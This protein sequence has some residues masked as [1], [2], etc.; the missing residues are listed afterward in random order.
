MIYMIVKIMI[1]TGT[2]LFASLTMKRDAAKARRVYATAFVLLIGVC[3]AFSIA[4]GAA[5][6]GFLSAA[7]SFSPIEVL[8]LIVG[9]YWLSYIT[10]GGKMFDKIIGE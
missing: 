4:Q 2:L 10:A 5:A 9:I 1:I 6:A 8:S 3:I 7:P